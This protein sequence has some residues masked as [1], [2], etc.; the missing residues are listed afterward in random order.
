MTEAVVDVLPID[1]GRQPQ[2]ALPSLGIG[3][4]VGHLLLL[5]VGSADRG[6]KID[7]LLGVELLDEEESVSLELSRIVICDGVE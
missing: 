2:L 5:L 1:I 3:A 6:E 4:G 7:F